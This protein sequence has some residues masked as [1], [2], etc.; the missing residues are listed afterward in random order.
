RQQ[1]NELLGKIEVQG[2]TREQR[3]KFYT[4]LWHLLLG[5]HILDD[6]NGDYPIYMG[7]KPSARSTAKLRVGRLPKDENGETLFHMYNSDALWLTMWNINLIW[8][9]GWPEMLDELSASWVQYADNGGLLPRGPSAGGYTYIMK[10]CPATSMITSAYQKNLLT[11]VD[12]EHA[13]ETMRRNHGPGGMLSIDDEPSLAHYVEKGWAP[14]NAGTTV[15]WAFED[16][17]LGQMAQDLGKKKDANYFDARS[18]GWKSLYHSGVGLLMPLKGDGEWLHDDP[19]SGEGWVEANAW[20][21]S[22]SVSHDIP[23][24]AKLMGG[25]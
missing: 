1:W 7:E 21:A 17:A 6:G 8:G 2:G 23:G 15:Q 9:L 13:Y 4:D 20:Q 11:K 25:N 5:R 10:G 22:F 18:K 3:V 16:W 14:D 12:V 24:L 19:L